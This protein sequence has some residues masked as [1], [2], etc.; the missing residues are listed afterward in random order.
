MKMNECEAYACADFSQKIHER[1]G[2]EKC[3]I[4]DNSIQV[5]YLG[6]R[7]VNQNRL[8]KKYECFLETKV[9]EK[10]ER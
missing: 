7:L 4:G 9:D 6:I 1:Y 3:D 10:I 5:G 2:V 8:W